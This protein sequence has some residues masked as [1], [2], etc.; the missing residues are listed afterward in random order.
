MRL[1]ERHSI[2]YEV[3]EFPTDVHS[4]VGVAEVLDVPPVTVFK[5]L[6]AQRPGGKPVLAVIPGPATLDLKALAATLGEK[7]LQMAAHVEAER[8]TGLLTGGISPLALTSKNW[9]VVLDAQA[10]QHD[11]ILISAGQRGI[12][13]RVAVADLKQLLQPAVAAITR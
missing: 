5:T 1:L 2:A 4:A 8:L 6:V 13:L 9:P 7:K 12:N 10:E 11:A 3:F